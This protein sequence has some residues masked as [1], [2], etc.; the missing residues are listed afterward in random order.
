MFIEALP[1]SQHGG[2]MCQQHILLHIYRNLLICTQA[3]ILLCLSRHCVSLND[4]LRMS[5]CHSVGTGGPKNCLHLLIF[6]H[7][8]MGYW[9]LT[10]RRQN[11]YSSAQKKCFSFSPLGNAVHIGVMIYLSLYLSMYVLGP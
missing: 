8:A 7:P 9:A 6:R 10:R 2:V 5:C 4:R 3:D 1:L 11:S